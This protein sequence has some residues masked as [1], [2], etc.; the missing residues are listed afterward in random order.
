M[1]RLVLTRKLN[2]GIVLH[3]DGKE[4]AHVKVHKIDKNQV[5]LVV[6]ADKEI[7]IDRQEVYIKPNK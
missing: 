3:S 1:S 6:E 5:R 4:I 7:K 2:D